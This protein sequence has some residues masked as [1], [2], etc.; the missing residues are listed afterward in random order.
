MRYEITRAQFYFRPRTESPKKPIIKPLAC[1]LGVPSEFSAN[2]LQ[3][4][5]VAAT[6]NFVHFTNLPLLIPNQEQ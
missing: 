4:S 3:L 6:Q 1:I 5:K 2:Y